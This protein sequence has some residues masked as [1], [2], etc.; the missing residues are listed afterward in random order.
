VCYDAQE[1]AKRRS[2]NKPSGA[3]ITKIMTVYRDTMRSYLIG[4]VLRAIKT[5]WP[6]ED[7][8]RTIWIQQDNARTHV[9]VDDQDFA[10][11]AAQTR[12]DICLIN[13][14]PN[15]PDMNV[16]DLGFFASLQSKTNTTTSR[17]LDELIANVEK[18]FQK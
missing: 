10:R 16:L 17:N 6:A 14:P 13:Q 11:A 1:P 3:L 9:P 5:H 18:E 7:A 8:G 15:S 4:K 2:G 12:F